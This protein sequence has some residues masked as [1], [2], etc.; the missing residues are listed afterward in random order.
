MESTKKGTLPQKNSRKLK[1]L[2]NQERL[3]IANLVSESKF[4]ISSISAQY[5]VSWDT[6]ARATKRKSFLEEGID[7]KTINPDSK[8]QKKCQYPKVEG[9]L[10]EWIEIARVWKLPLTK[11]LIQTKALE[12]Y[13]K[14]QEEMPDNI[15]DSKKNAFKASDGWFDGFKNRYKL[16][17]NKLSGESASSE[18]G[19]YGE[20]LKQIGEEILKFDPDDVYN[21]DETGLFYKMLPDR[22]YCLES[23]KNPHG[24][25]IKKDRITAILCCNL[26]GTHKLPVAI[27]GSRNKPRCFNRGCPPIPYFHSPKAWINFDIYEKWFS[28]IFV[29]C[30]RGKSNRPVLLILDNCSVHHKIAVE[31]VTII[32]LPPNLTSTSQPLDQG[33]ISA[34]KKQYKINVLKKVTDNMDQFIQNSKKIRQKSGLH[35]GG[36]PDV[37]DAAIILKESWESISPNTIKKC[38]IHSNLLI[39]PLLA[40][41]ENMIDVEDQVDYN[42]E[43]EEM[44]IKLANLYLPPFHDDKIAEKSKGIYQHNIK[45]WLEGDI[46]EFHSVEVVDELLW[47]QQSYLNDAEYNEATE[48][49]HSQSNETNNITNT[50]KFAHLKILCD[51]MQSIIQSDDNIKQSFQNIELFNFFMQGLEHLN[52]FCANSDETKADNSN[53]NNSK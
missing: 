13:R 4:S 14:L 33:I 1:I 36:L 53:N 47:D 52:D 51:E 18:V 41:V 44:C 7:G 29:S 32:F 8:R 40:Q 49:H 10:Y 42:G 30:V 17:S 48:Q 15:N 3:E 16:H 24:T 27:I 34:V 37:L 9:K 21:M 35:Q 39:E 46:D 11:N 2:S 23:E 22:T 43:V 50:N 19:K 12:N 25:K 6:V 26:S 28:R 38:W 20:E 45:K 5:G 31:N